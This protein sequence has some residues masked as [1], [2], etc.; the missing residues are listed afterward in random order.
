MRLNPKTPKPQN[1]LLC[2]NLNRI[3]Y[4]MIYLDLYEVG[5]FEIFKGIILPLFLVFFFELLYA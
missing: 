3:T 5:F 1:P 4:K 2:L